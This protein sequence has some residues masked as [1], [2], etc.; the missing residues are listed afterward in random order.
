MIM[1]SGITY[2]DT[3]SFLLMSVFPGSK[4]GVTSCSKFAFF[5]VFT[6]AIVWLLTI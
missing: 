6:Y 5:F 2:V 4:L 3:S 1:E